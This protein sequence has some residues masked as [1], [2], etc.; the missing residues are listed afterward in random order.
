MGSLALDSSPDVSFNITS[1]A[2][3]HHSVRALN[4]HNAIMI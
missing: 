3:F 1:L 4:V 2:F